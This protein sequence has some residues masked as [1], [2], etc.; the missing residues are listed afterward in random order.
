MQE[1]I[2]NDAN[3]YFR[4]VLILTTRTNSFGP[5]EISY[6]EHKF[7]S[8]IREAARYILKNSNEPS[9]GNVTEEK[10]AE[11]DEVIENTKLIIGSIGYK[12]F[13][14]IVK[15]Y[16]QETIDLSQDNVLYLKRNVKRL[17][18]YIED[19]CQVTSEGFVVLAGSM[20]AEEADNIPVA[21]KQ[22]REKLVKDNIIVDG[23]LK[24]D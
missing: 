16:N 24:V 4:E 20:I 14:P 22:L 9:I 7:V 17:G 1:H 5:T 6:L 18:K 13:V 10:E 23:I 12:L 19:K 2:R 3:D 15:K 11:L 21:L 8:L